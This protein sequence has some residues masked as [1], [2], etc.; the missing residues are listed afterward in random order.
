[1][2]VAVAGRHAH[3]LQEARRGGRPG[4]CTCSTCDVRETQL[5]ETRSVDDQ[6]EWLDDDTV[7][8]GLD[9]AVAVIPADGS[10]QPTGPSPEQTP[11]P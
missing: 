1:M 5:A 9:G 8:Y 3:R 6:A 7:L 10:G 2:P 4:A 11:A